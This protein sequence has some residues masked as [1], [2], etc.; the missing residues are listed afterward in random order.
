MAQG[1]LAQVQ[2]LI[3]QKMKENPEEM[4]RKLKEIEEAKEKAKKVPKTPKAPPKTLIDPQLTQELIKELNKDSN[5]LDI[6]KV[7]DLIKRGA[8]IKA[9]NKYDYTVLHW[10]SY[11]EDMELAKECLQAGIDVNAK[12]INGITPLFWAAYEDDIEMQ[13]LLKQHGAIE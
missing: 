5:E 8:D 11:F 3:D 9:K 2:A 12:N 1:Y 10:A 4:K 6:Q 13:D 7:K